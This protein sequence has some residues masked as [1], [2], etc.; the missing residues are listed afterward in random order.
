MVKNDGIVWE[1]GGTE[2]E[3][4]AGTARRY[5]KPLKSFRWCDLQA[6]LADTVNEWYKHKAPRLGASLAFYTLLSLA[7][8]LVV[9]VALAGAFYGEEA[10]RGQIVAQLSGLVGTTGASVIEDV[11]KQ[12]RQPAA[13]IFATAAGLLTLF[14]GAT[15]VVT[16]LRDALNTIYEIPAP[17]VRGLR[18]VLLFVRERFFSF[19]MVVGVGFLLLVSLAVSAWLAALG[20]WFNGWLPTLL[21]QSGN[22]LISWV[23]IAGLFAAIYKTLPD[24]TLEWR[25]VAL[26]AAVT[27]LLFSL[28][29]FL[30]GLYLGSSTLASA[31]GAAGSLVVLLIWVYYSAQI[32]FLGAEFTQV[33]A[34]RY[35]SQPTLRARRALL[36]RLYSTPPNDGKP[37]VTPSAP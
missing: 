1:P 22:T 21:L 12:A 13:G 37:L 35:G 31:Y 30:I 16:E 29:K 7:P 34:N 33:F 25:D 15:G 26:G 23:I 19:A 17:E 24:V 2:A 5:R 14:F 20:A 11:I 6:L 28:G 32:F 8:L 9:I 27:S 18:T 4:A 10:A 3:T 36:G